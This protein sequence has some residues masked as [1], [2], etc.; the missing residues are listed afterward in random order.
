MKKRILIVTHSRDLHADRIVPLLEQRGH[1]YLRLDLDAFPRDYEFVQSVLDRHCSNRLR[2]LDDAPVDLGEVGAVWNRK[3]AD[4]AYRSADLGAQERAYAKRETEQALFGALYS[5]DCFWMSHPR[6]L[7]GAQWKGEQ[8]KR[9]A[10]MGFRVPRSIVTNSPHEVR[11]FRDSVAGPIIFKTL[12]SPTLAS[13][14]IA[15][16]ER[17]AT[18]LITTLIDDDMLGQLDAVAELPCHFQEYVAK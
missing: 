11:R 6:A 7:R 8:L 12:S 10:R 14:D 4:F 2:R 16:H 15:P 9:A 18:G 13:E 1:P 5:L 3:A 17:V